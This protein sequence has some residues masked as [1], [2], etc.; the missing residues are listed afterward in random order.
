MGAAGADDGRSAALREAMVRD[1]LIARGIRDARVLAAFRK[2]RRDLFIPD[3]APDMAYEDHPI[4][5]GCSQTIS[6]PYIVARTLECLALTPKDRALEIGTGSGYQT[7]LLAE[8]CREVDSIERIAELAEAARSRLRE[9]GY[10]NIEVRVADGT[11]GWP[12][13]APY[14]AIVVSAAA[15]HM[16]QPLLDQLADGGRMVIPVGDLRGQNLMLVERKGRA[17]KTRSICGCVF[18]RLIGEE[19]WSTKEEV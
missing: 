10:A 8:L 17:L 3:V 2:V 19:G 12:E 14:D 4:A 11:L 9:T 15:P 13:K 6:Q 7:A 18:V 16:P 5:I 1:Q